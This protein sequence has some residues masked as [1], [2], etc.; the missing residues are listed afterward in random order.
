MANNNSITYWNSIKNTYSDS[1][2]NPDV[3]TASIFND[4]NRGLMEYK[5]RNSIQR[6]LTNSSIYTA[7]GSGVQV[8]QY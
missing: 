3:V 2:P 4:M 8:V 7:Y 1:L 6:T 5:W